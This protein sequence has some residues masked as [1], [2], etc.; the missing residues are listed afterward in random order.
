M[1]RT[2]NQPNSTLSISFLE[3]QLKDLKNA[4]TSTKQIKSEIAH[5]KSELNKLYTS[6]KNYVLEFEKSN[7]KY[8]VLMRS[9]N[10]FYKI[11]GHSALYYTYSLA[12][13]LNLV[14][15][16]QDDK[17]F[18]SKSNEGF[19]SIKNLQALTDA[20]ATLNIKLIKTKNTTGDFLVYKFPW[21]FTN[22]QI[23]NYAEQNLTKLQKFNHIVIVDNIIPILF[24][25]IEE[26]LKAVYE[27]VRGMNGPIERE[28]FGYQIIKKTTHMAH[29]YLGLANGYIPKLN[30]LKQIKSDLKIVK[31]Q[32]KILADLKIWTPKTCA[33]IGEIIIKIQD[34][35]T[36]EIKHI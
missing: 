17:D 26:L 1:Q 2:N 16:L 28:A 6:N 30:C 14:A 35:V 36:H 24:L 27:N 23:T 5:I 8:L 15:H 33:R 9:T 13:K 25:Q 31:Y 11:F 32:T 19:V 21:Q 20:L 29:L 4:N 22:Q 18:T 10:G 3:Q 7:Y 34:I 12:P